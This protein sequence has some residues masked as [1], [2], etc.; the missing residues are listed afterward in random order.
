M[1]AACDALPRAGYLPARWLESEFGAQDSPTCTTLAFSAWGR[2][3]RLTMPSL[4][5]AQTVSLARFLRSTGTDAIRR[6]PVADVVRAIDHCCNRLLDPDEPLRRMLDDSLPVITGFDPEML[7]IGLNACLRTYRA[8]QLERFLAADFSD[9]R[10]LDRFVPTPAGGW[11]RAVGADLLALVWAGNVPGLPLW[12]LVSGL[13]TRAAIIGKLPSAEPLLAGVFASLLAQIEPRLADAMAAVWWPGGEEAIES[14]L[15]AQADTV[16]AYGSNDT[17]A[18][19]GRC[20]P[21]SVRYLT[22]GHKLSLGVVSRTALDDRSARSLAHQA[23]L[24]VM[25]WD[26]HGCYSPQQ[27]FVEAGGKVSPRE[28]AEWLGYELSALQHR[29]PRRGLALEETNALASWRSAGQWTGEEAPAIGE[30][31]APWAVRFDASGGPVVASPLNRSVQVTAVQHIDDILST[32]R[33]CCDLLQT[34][35]LAASPQEL[36][37]LAPLLAQ[38]GVTRICAI[39]EMSAPAPGWHH[40]GRFSLSDLVR[41]VDIEPSAETAAERFSAFRD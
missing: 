13:L 9:P 15:F 17:L 31:Q 2:S 38:A 11:A 26:Q 1:T 6:V 37:R 34:A 18:K 25:R 22:H 36:F 4:D 10:I 32:L 35:G 39:G 40:D 41:M 12:S 33:D 3:I 19:I 30:A 29:F 14:A 20:V 16:L 24:D 27:F 8:P 21:A 28:W 5:T 23:A 7:R